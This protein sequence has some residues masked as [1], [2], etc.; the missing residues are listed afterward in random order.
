MESAASTV[1]EF[2]TPDTFTLAQWPV[3]TTLLEMPLMVTALLLQ[4]IVRFS[5]IPEMVRLAPAGAVGGALGDAE[6]DVDGAGAEV[7]APL[8]GAA[9]LVEKPGLGERVVKPL[10]V[11]LWM[12]NTAS[13]S[14]IAMV[15]MMKKAAKIHQTRLR[16]GGRGDIQGDGLPNVGGGDG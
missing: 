8:E 1:T 16:E 13:P 15:P 3:I 2:W 5:L 7:C 11:A 9:T 14:G 10:C 6:V 12:P 4:A